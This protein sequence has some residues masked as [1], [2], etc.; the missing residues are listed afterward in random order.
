MEILSYISKKGIENYNNYN[1]DIMNY[2]TD[3]CYVIDG[4]T[5]LYNDHL[6]FKTSD[7]YEYMQLLKNNISNSDSIKNSLINGIIKSNKVFGE[8]NNIKEY[9]LPTFT[10]A[11]VKEKEDYYELYLL[12]D[13]LISILY[14]NGK[15]ENIYDHRFDEINSKIIKGIEDVNKL[16]MIVEAKEELKKAIYRKYRK[17]ANKKDG[18]SV[19][20]MVPDSI[21]KGIEMKIKKIDIDRIL[22]CT[23]GL[24]NE[25]GIPDNKEY[26]KKEFLEEKVLN[27]D[28]S[29]DLTYILIDNK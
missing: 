27:K 22:I 1:N 6:V 24:Y 12:C 18:Y 26:F 4:A 13:C 7:A 29:D 2:Y 15:I 16:E 3:F 25:I 11:A 8:V 10:I 23:D 17:Y 21:N 28:N 14:K 9:E 5:P 19:G 20:S